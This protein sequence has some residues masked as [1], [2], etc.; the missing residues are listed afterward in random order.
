M[1]ALQIIDKIKAL[2]AEAKTYDSQGELKAKVIDYR[3]E[4]PEFYD[5]YNMAVRDYLDIKV[6]A[7][8]SYFPERLFKHKS[9]NINQEEFEYLKANYKNTTIPVFLDFVNSVNRA[10]SKGNWSLTFTDEK[11]EQY[12]SEQKDYIE[13]FKTILP[14]IKL[15]DANGVVAVMPIYMMTQDE[16]GN[17]T[18]DDTQEPEIELKYYPTPDVWWKGGKAFICLE[19]DRVPVMYGTQERKYG[20]AFTAYTD[21]EIIRIVQTGRYTDHEFTVQWSINHG[22]K[23]TP[24]W[25]LGGI[26]MFTDA[27]FIYQSPFLFAV[28]NLDLALINE[29][30]LQTSLQLTMYPYRVMVGDECDF[31]QDGATCYKGVV[32]GMDG[33][34]HTCPSCHGTG[35]KNRPSRMGT[36]LVN[37]AP[38]NGDA[39]KPAE[40]MVFVQPGTDGL[41]FVKE[42]ISENER[43]ARNI[44]HL[45]DTND[46]PTGKE[47]TA[48][49]AKIDQESQYAFIKNVSDGIF[50]IMYNVLWAMGELRYA[51]EFQGFNLTEPVNFDFRSREDYAAAILAAQ[52][53]GVPVLIEQAIYEAIQH[54]FHANE[55]Q[56]AAFELLKLVDSVFVYSPDQIDTGIKDGTISRRDAVLHFRYLTIVENILTEDENFFDKSIADQI[57]AVQD[58]AQ[59]YVVEIDAERGAGRQDLIS[60]IT[61]AAII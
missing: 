24:A 61:G 37:T 2:M 16:Q 36:M 29:N 23:Y 11:F 12:V 46:Q 52:K 59:A 35:L 45:Y 48:T 7:E 19:K 43:K 34:N 49:G 13:W 28:D 39:I 10:F 4:W 56:D 54:Y 44:L 53:M 3:E 8:R 5:G 1:D 38:L 41:R 57:Q 40:S 9:P 25:M 60:A 33:E 32:R 42:V 18:I 27:A 17:I 47:D 31:E 58:A 30:N 51:A 20:R 26:P 15:K 6:H 14:T 55:I 21:T 22:L 50:R